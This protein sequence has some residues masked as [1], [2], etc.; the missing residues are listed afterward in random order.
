[1]SPFG[2]VTELHFSVPA[3]GLLLLQLSGLVVH[4]N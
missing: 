3:Q 1:M 2:P 4:E